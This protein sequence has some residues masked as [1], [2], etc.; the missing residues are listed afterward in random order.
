MRHIG[1]VGCSPPG[2]ALCYELVSSGA[3]EAEVSAHS[4]PFETYLGHMRANQWEAVAEL[5]LDSAEKLDTVGAE[6]L[7]APCNTI[8]QAMDLVIPRSPLPW[9]HIAAEVANEARRRG[10][11]RIAL[12]GTRWMMES[13]VYPEHLGQVGLDCEIPDDRERAELDH[14][15][16]T[17]MV[18][19]KFT[20]EART[21]VE[22]VIA[23]MKRNGCDAAGLCCTEL[24]LLLEGV[25]PGLP[26]LDS[27]RILANAALERSRKC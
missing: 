2:A 11:R 7:I 3:G 6:F 8:H 4:H 26:L 13:P 9:L 20:N 10:Y 12:L 25:E 27:T 23:R 17:E 14:Y 22:S 24:P 16:L 5:M 18:A 21:Q 19:G 1:I 15:I